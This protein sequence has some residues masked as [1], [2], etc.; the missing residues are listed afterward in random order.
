MRACHP[1]LVDGGH[2]INVRSGAQ[3]VVVP[4]SAT[5]EWDWYG[6]TVSCLSAFVLNEQPTEIGRIVMSLADP[7]PSFVSSRAMTADSAGVRW[8][9]SW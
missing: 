8:I 6:I 2:V 1:Y 4:D 9:R 7:E 5:R 3:A